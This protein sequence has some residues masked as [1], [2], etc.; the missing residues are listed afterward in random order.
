MDSLAA[1]LNIAKED[2]KKA[3]ESAVRTINTLE[4]TISKLKEELD[5]TQVN[6]IREKD[7]AAFTIDDLH[8]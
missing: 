2:Y 4:S 3:D 5:L 7:R 1:E 6:Y 8:R